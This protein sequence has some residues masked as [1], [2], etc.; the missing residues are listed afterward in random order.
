VQSP[1]RDS[2][3]ILTNGVAG[4]PI[5][6]HDMVQG[7][8]RLDNGEGGYTRIQALSFAVLKSLLPSPLPERSLVKARNREW[9]IQTSSGEDPSQSSWKFTA[10][11]A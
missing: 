2:F 7:E 4:K 5:T 1:F 11:P 3:Q 10:I 6:A 8:A 9:I